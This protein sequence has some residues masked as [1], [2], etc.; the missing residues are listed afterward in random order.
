[1]AAVGA[2]HAAGEAREHLADL[3]AAP[4]GKTTHLAEAMGNSG[5]LVAVDNHPRRLQDLKLN[6]RRWGVTVAH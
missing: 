4:G 3:A 5:L 6:M 2:A 1:M